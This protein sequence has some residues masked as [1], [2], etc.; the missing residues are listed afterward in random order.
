MADKRK[1]SKRGYLSYFV[2]N[3]AGEYIYSGKLYSLNGEGYGAFIA[4]LSVLSFL[5]LASCVVSGSITAPGMTNSFY[6]IIPFIL[7]IAAEVSVCWAAC[8]FI[9][10]KKPLREYIYDSVIKTVP[11]R[12]LLAA[13]CAL[14]GIISETVF[15]ILNGAGEN[16]LW[17][18]LYYILKIAVAVFMF[19]L[20][21][22]VKKTVWTPSDGN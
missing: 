11:L 13:V 1:F 3:A 2:K 12:A 8:R 20:R 21:R 9:V 17:C 5:S 18:V 6:V 16:V 14:A 19:L 10:N 15:V 4:K 22:Y 7:E